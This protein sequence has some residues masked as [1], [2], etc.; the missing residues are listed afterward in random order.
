MIGEISVNLR[1]EARE[2]PFT[3]FGCLVMTCACG[4]GIFIS[5]V[6]F[7]ITGL[8]NDTECYTPLALWSV[9]VKKV[10]LNTEIVNHS[11]FY[12]SS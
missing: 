4:M 3:S 7:F 1:I 6:A 5:R 2:T 9:F 10:N 8:G 11:I 12:Y